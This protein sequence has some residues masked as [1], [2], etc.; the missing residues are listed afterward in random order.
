VDTVGEKAKVIQ[1]LVAAKEEPRAFE[2][3]N[4]VREIKNV[5][6]EDGRYGD[7]TQV[8]DQANAIIALAAADTGVSPLAA[9]WLANAQC[10]D[11]GWQFDQPSG[12]NDDQH[13]YSGEGDYST[14]DTN[15]TSLAVQA[16][17]AADIHYEAEL[18]RSPFAF[19][20]WARDEVK[21]GWGFTRPYLTDANSTSLVIQAYVAAGRS[22]PAGGKDALRVLQYRLCD[23]DGAFAYSWEDYDA[24]GTYRKTGP[25]LGA[26]IQAIFGLLEKPFPIPGRALERGVSAPDC[27]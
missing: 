9:Y 6:Q 5:F 16:F 11:G 10:A 25:D 18:K 20:R 8:F 3:R 2:G 7:G 17:H 21:G 14:S 27:Q 15:T 4:L 22:L 26:T 12:P 24:D 23:K 1:A 19:F 13:C